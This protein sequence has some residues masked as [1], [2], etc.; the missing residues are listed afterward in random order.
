MRVVLKNKLDIYLFI[1]SLAYSLHKLERGAGFQP[2]IDRTIII[3][4]PRSIR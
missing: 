3:T 1:R 4:N 2:A